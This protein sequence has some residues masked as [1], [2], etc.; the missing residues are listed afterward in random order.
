MEDDTREVDELTI[1]GTDGGAGAARRD[2]E[3]SVTL[4]ESQRRRGE[5]AD[6]DG[7]VVMPEEGDETDDAYVVGAVMPPSKVR[8]VRFRAG[9]DVEVGEE[10]ELFFF[11]PNSDGGLRDGAMGRWGEED[12]EGV[13]NPL[14][15]DSGVLAWED[16]VVSVGGESR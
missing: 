4:L 2:A 13:A 16:D 12:R 5:D 6:A 9:G 1:D 7:V 3:E 15:S 10:R 14:A 8:V 11:A